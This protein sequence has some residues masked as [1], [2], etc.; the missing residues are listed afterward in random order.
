MNI[1]QDLGSEFTFGSLTGVCHRPVNDCM[2]Y[3]N[4]KDF[5]QTRDDPR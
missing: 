2:Y 5:G 3:L 4:L 1:E